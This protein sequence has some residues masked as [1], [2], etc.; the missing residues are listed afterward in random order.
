MEISLFNWIFKIKISW[1]KN[2]QISSP[3]CS[4]YHPLTKWFW[5]LNW[6]LWKKNS[7]TIFSFLR[8]NSNATKFIHS[9]RVFCRRE[10]HCVWVKA[11]SMPVSASMISSYS[12]LLGDVMSIPFAKCLCISSVYLS[13]PCILKWI[14]CLKTNRTNRCCALILCLAFSNV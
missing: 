8:I 1:Q 6:I 11:T 14:G 3:C 12:N 2:Y 9:P 13:K 10:S 7:L 4:S 5:P